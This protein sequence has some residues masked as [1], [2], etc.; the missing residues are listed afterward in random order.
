MKAC[1]V[2]LFAAAAIG[3]T[4]KKQP[5]AK[6]NKLC[7]LNINLPFESCNYE[8]DTN[9]ILTDSAGR[10]IKAETDTVT[11]SGGLITY[12]LAPGQY[13]YSVTTIFNDTVSRRIRL[14]SSIYINIYNDLY[15]VTNEIHPDSICKALKTD[16]LVSILNDEDSNYSGGMFRFI[17]KGGRFYA[18]HNFSGDKSWSTPAFIDSAKLVKALILFQQAISD[19]NAFDNS[20]QAAWYP[21]PSSVHIRCND[22]YTENWHFKSNY[23]QKAFNQLR[24]ALGQ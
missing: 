24:K 4:G 19:S 10:T 9:F 22:N 23:L 21:E 15:H 12:Q 11:K 2:L 18:R 20:R 3:C 7:E 6:T 5:A 8:N 17:K 16:I 1:L 14:D 13:Q